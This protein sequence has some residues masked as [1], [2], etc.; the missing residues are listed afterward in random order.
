MDEIR[1][2]LSE[3]F[4]KTLV[5]YG[6]PVLMGLLGLAFARLGMWLK[7]RTKHQ[8]LAT[9][10]MHLN[11]SV[12]TAVRQVEQ[13]IRPLLTEAAMDGVITAQERAQLKAQAMLAVKAYLG[14]QGMA[15]VQSALGLQSE[16]HLETMLD[17]RIEAA[18]LEMKQ[19]AG[20]PFDPT[21]PARIIPI[22]Q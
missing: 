18:V 9:A 5:E 16:G 21:A 1:Q 15:N 13:T 17:G 20:T 7:T 6:I 19:G 10:L 22:R 12:A 14:E 8:Q 2:A 11:D 4:V 3:Q